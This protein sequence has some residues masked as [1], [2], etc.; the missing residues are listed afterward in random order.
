M[1][2]GIEDMV[3]M[4]ETSTEHVSFVPPLEFSFPETLVYLSRSANECLYTVKNGR[5]IR[6][7]R[8]DG[9]PVV[10]EVTCHGTDIH[11]N[12]PGGANEH[13]RHS[14][15]NYVWE[16][17]DLGTDIRPFY[18]L[19]KK[20][21]LLGPLSQKYFGLRVIG[22]PD[23][24]EALCWAVIGQQI[25]LTF[26]Y[27]L[28]RRFVEAYG[29]SMNWHGDTHWMFPTP[30][31]I[32]KVSVEDLK[33]LQFTEKKSEYVIEVA[34]RISC[35]EL[36]KANLQTQSFD[37]AQR[38]LLGLRGIGPWTA[39]YVLMRCLHDPSAFPIQDVGMHNAIKANL[40]MDRKPTLPEIEQ[41]ATGWK[42]WEAYATFYLWR[43]LYDQ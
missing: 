34:R 4:R 36:T 28:K 17:F 5:V 18:E 2:D 22:I 26:A 42:G 14:V 24:F 13:T 6:S 39:N 23:L 16:W 33:K 15:A 29:E 8:V 12:F 3:Q 25:N 31:A 11:V 40:G 43:S 27:T 7:I 41:L 30:E 35:G 19:V 10:F 20:D 38:E 32:A 21:E 9:A 37:D 1:E